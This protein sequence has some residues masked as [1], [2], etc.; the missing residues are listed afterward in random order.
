[1][2]RVVPTRSWVGFNYGA[3]TRVL[4]KKGKNKSAA[5]DDVAYH[6]NFASGQ[7]SGNHVPRCD[8]PRDDPQESFC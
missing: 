7:I 6:A 1:M 5:T 2:R 3:S 8:T 4:W